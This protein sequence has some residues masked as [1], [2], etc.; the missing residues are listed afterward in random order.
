MS[1]I[2]N[3]YYYYQ[4]L[5][6][7]R[8]KEFSPD[9]FGIFPCDFSP[10]SCTHWTLLPCVIQA[11][12]WI[13][14][15]A[16]DSFTHVPTFSCCHVLASLRIREG[17]FVTPEAPTTAGSQIWILSP[18]FLMKIDWELGKREF[19]WIWFCLGVF[20]PL[21]SGAQEYSNNGK[22]HSGNTLRFPAKNQK[23]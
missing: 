13:F 16:P 6:K 8:N 3:Y 9:H 18:S 14:P 15:R 2:I 22:N 5:W 21:R 1:I 7:L 19:F 4:Q 10:S 20:F 23:K 17:N 12:E 11:W